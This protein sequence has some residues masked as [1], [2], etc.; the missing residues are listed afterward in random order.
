MATLKKT[1]GQEF[2]SLR[3]HNTRLCNPEP[4][5]FK[6]IKLPKI[7]PKLNIKLPPGL[8]AIHLVDYDLDIN[9][10]WYIDIHFIEPISKIIT[11]KKYSKNIN[12]YSTV[13]ERKF[14]AEQIIKKIIDMLG[15]GYI[16]TPKTKFESLFQNESDDNISLQ[17]AFRK[18]IGTK[19][20]HA[21][22][23]I[24][25]YKATL[26][27]LAD[28]EKGH[29]PILL[30][31]VKPS[32]INQI[33]ESIQSVRKIEPKTFNHYRNSFAAVFNYWVRQGIINRSPVA[34]IPTKKVQIGRVHYPLTLEQIK[35]IK[36]LA[37]K[38]GDNQFVL[39]ISFMFYALVRP[40]R[41][42]RFLKVK[43]ILE[44][45]FWI[46]AE[47]SKPGQSRRIEMLKPLKNLIYSQQIRNY[48]PEFFVFTL[49]GKPGK[50]NVGTRFFYRRQVKYLEQLNLLGKNHD[51][52]CYKH[53]G[54]IQMIKA[55]FTPFE[56][57]KIAGHKDVKQTQEYLY[58][59]GAI[60]M[61]NGKGD[62]M[63]YI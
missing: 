51:L 22:Q 11:R 32:D 38:E 61:L 39:L 43:H 35:D 57:M 12:K 20:N 23:T 27:Y 62:N 40:G 56:V 15:N 46:S 8:H 17:E 54:A 42:L 55:G 7:L 2:E 16:F 5:I 25:R 31:N 10:K 33:L 29:K 58:N 28:Y 49:D 60:S 3:L 41:E 4:C 48:D 14:H 21:Y 50:I 63:P 36:E 37:I 6:K 34:A 13:V 53:S 47:N 52:Y 44:D 9:K 19:N 45:S 18:F 26:E 30:K 24:R 59:I 1:D